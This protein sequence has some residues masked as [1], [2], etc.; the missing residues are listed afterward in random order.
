M[1]R[2]AYFRE[3]R[4]QNPGYKQAEGQRRWMRKTGKQ[5]RTIILGVKV[6]WNLLGKLP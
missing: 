2:T 1:K 5:P 3:W 6:R 4:R